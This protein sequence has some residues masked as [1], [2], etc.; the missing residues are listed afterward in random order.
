MYVTSHAFSIFIVTRICYSCLLLIV[1]RIPA[2][3]H[4]YDLFI[5]AILV[6]TAGTDYE[7]VSPISQ[8]ALVYGHNDFVSNIDN[9]T[10][11]NNK[12]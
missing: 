4:I 12:L 7:T 11:I 3:V 2:S 9:N 10:F 5:L 6:R 8:I 1:A